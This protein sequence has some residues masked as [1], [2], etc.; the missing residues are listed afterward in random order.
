MSAAGSDAPGGGS[1]A[2]EKSPVWSHCSRGIRWAALVMEGVL[3]TS[4]AN[5]GPWPHIAGNTLGANE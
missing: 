1:L 4:I 2:A 5:V 3:D